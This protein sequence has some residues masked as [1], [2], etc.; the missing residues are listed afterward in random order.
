MNQNRLNTKQTKKK[1][2]KMPVIMS[3]NT[4]LNVKVTLTEMI[5]VLGPDPQAPEKGST[6]TQ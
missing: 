3:Q 4:S 6:R 5:V 2:Y 1:D